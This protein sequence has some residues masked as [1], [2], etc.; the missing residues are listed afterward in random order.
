MV[1]EDSVAQFSEGCAVPTYTVLNVW[2]PSGI[3]DYVSMGNVQQL[4][5]LV[6]IF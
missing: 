5:G 4:L 3:D 6:Q 1:I 2:W